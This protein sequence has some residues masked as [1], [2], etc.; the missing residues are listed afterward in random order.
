[1]DQQHA[2]A[3]CRER[4]SSGPPPVCSALVQT[5]F[6]RPP[7]ALAPPG[8]PPP[9]PGTIV[10]QKPP[11]QYPNPSFARKSVKKKTRI[12]DAPDP[13]EQK[14]SRET[15]GHISISSVEMVRAGASVMTF[16]VV[17]AD[18]QDQ[19]RICLPPYSRV[20][21]EGFLDEG[22]SVVARSR[23]ESRP[24]PQISTRQRAHLPIPAEPSRP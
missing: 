4:T 5:P 3:A 22:R 21:L 2:D 13:V 10:G 1:M 14:R 24:S 18:V 20:A 19:T 16:L 12:S 17:A 11:P 9:Q 7:I 15:Q 6:K 8:K 23:R